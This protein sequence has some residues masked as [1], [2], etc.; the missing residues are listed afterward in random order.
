MSWRCTRTWLQH[1]E[2]SVELDVDVIRQQDV[3]GIDAGCRPARA[4]RRA[5]RQSPSSRRR[6]FRATPRPSTGIRGAGSMQVKAQSMPPSRSAPGQEARGVARVDLDDPLRADL[7]HQGIGGRA[8]EGGRHRLAPGGPL[9]GPEVPVVGQ[10][11]GHRRD[12]VT[13]EPVPR[14]GSRSRYRV[15]SVAPGRGR[16]GRG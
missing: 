6:G 15:W 4:R 1:R 14:T 10:V 16:S 8:V 11:R 5:R 13:E 7:A 9:V 3:A 12:V 2:D